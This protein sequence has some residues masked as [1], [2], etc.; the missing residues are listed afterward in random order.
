MDGD[1]VIYLETKNEEQHNTNTHSQATT[2]EKCFGPLGESEHAPWIVN[3][4][5]KT[6]HM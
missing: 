2:E 3:D 4:E 5:Q 6:F 1:W